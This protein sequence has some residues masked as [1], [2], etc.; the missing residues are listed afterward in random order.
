M[1]NFGDDFGDN[2]DENMSYSVDLSDEPDIDVGSKINEA[3]GPDFDLS[4]EGLF[5]G[6]SFAQHRIWDITS[7]TL[8]TAIGTVLNVLILLVLCSGDPGDARSPTSLYLTHLALADLLMVISFPI[9]LL[10][11]EFGHEW[12]DSQ[13]K[14]ACFWE[15]PLHW[16]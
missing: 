7:T 1:M 2:G 10:T 8:Y 14:T 11:I 3:F 13:H 12:S 5:D 9:G 16:G 6:S 4:N 15:H